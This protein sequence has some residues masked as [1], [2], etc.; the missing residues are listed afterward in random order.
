MRTSKIH[1]WQPTLHTP[2]GRLLAD[3]QWNEGRVLSEGVTCIAC[4]RASTLVSLGLRPH[5]AR[6]TL[7]GRTE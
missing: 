5:P 3:V 6:A 2:C 4:N 7:E 1:R